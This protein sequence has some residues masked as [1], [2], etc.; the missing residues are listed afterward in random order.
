MFALLFGMGG[1]G[2]VATYQLIP[3]V[4]R[5]DLLLL[6]QSH[7]LGQLNG[8]LDGQRVI[9]VPH[10]ASMSCPHFVGLEDLIDHHVLIG[11][12]T[13]APDQVRFAFSCGCSQ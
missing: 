11:H 2:M 10:W 8:E 9:I 13:A 7:D 5:D 4:E 12:S 6:I 1:G 3:E